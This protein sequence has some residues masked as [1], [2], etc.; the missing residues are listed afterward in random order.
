MAA[1]VPLHQVQRSRIR[2]GE[3][4]GLRENEV[5]ERLQ[6]ALRRE[7]HTD[8]RELRQLTTAVGRFHPR[9]PLGHE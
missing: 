3:S 4:P 8:G 6:V 9:G 5:E 7:G 1:L 2:G